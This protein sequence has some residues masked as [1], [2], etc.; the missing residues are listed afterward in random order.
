MVISW[1]GRKGNGP[2]GMTKQK[3]FNQFFSAFCVCSVLF[4]PH[5]PFRLQPGTW[6]SLLAEHTSLAYS[7]LKEKNILYCK[8]GKA[9]KMSSKGFSS[10]IT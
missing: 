6:Q 1:E 4:L 8:V 2:R 5:P 7:S 9:F 3:A 10:T